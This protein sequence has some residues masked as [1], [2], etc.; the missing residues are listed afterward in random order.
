M[1]KA[2][3]SWALWVRSVLAVRLV[4]PLVLRNLA[5]VRITMWVLFRV[6]GAGLVR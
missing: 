3:S 1:L 2:V 5:K 6:K 4:V